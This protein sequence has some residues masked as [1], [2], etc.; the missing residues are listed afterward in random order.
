MGGGGQSVGRN[1]SRERKAAPQCKKGALSCAPARKFDREGG[2]PAAA[3]TAAV[4]TAAT[5]AA[6]ATTAAARATILAGTSLADVERAS[7]HLGLVQRSDRIIGTA[8]HLDEAE[9]ARPAG[10]PVG[11]QV[12]RL[13]RPIGLEEVLDLLVGSR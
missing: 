11:D 5:V 4:A 9:A 7:T 13:D 6:A 1:D 8:F 2:L 3:A 12:D 10:V